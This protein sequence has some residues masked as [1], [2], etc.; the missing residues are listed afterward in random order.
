M[1][2]SK[3]TGFKQ[4]GTMKQITPEEIAQAATSANGYKVYASKTKA[5]PFDE[6]FNV[7]A[8]W[9]ISQMQPE[10]VPVTERLPK[11]GSDVYFYR[12]GISEYV[13]EGK[14]IGAGFFE[15]GVIAYDTTVTHFIEKVK[16]Q[17]PTK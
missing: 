5:E 7:G 14:Y 6:G 1:R 10:W 12:E 11:R 15:Q 16:P 9:A 2:L 4:G 8:K 13:Y 3:N 17:P